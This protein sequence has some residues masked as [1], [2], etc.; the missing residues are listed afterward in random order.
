M[1]GV[2]QSYEGRGTGVATRDQTHSAGHSNTQPAQAPRSQGHG[3][4]RHKYVI[5]SAHREYI[6]EIQSI[7][8]D[9]LLRKSFICHCY[10]C[11]EFVQ[12]GLSTN[13]VPRLLRLGLEDVLFIVLHVVALLRR[14]VVLNRHNQV[15]LLRGVKVVNVH[16]DFL[17]SVLLLKRLCLAVVVER[18]L[19]QDLIPSG[20]QALKEQICLHCGDH[21]F[22]LL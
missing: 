20:A 21:V 11:I 3:L 5:N 10:T 17:V 18:V 13:E 9:N 6:S 14:L 16:G 12:S 19:L 7:T 4:M 2:T 22:L 15:W 8:A 1:C